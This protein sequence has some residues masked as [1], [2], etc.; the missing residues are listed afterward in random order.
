LC[1]SGALKVAAPTQH[2]D[3][4]LEKALSYLYSPAMTAPN[5]QLEE[6][7]KCLQEL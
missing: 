1:V 5:S 6:N 3:K 2:G 7:E 4:N